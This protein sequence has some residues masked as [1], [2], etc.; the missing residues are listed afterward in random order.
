M[1]FQASRPAY[2][3]DA[4]AARLNVIPLERQTIED[5]AAAVVAAWVE[6]G[7]KM[8]RCDS[9]RSKKEAGGRLTV[10]GLACKHVMKNRQ[11][12]YREGNAGEV[13]KTYVYS[14]RTCMCVGI[15]C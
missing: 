11:K 4:L 12:E 1:W 5:V 9:K 7:V 10:V 2:S 8:R 13:Q 6:L 15:L 14:V 3:A